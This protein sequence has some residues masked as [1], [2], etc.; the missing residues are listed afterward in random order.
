MWWETRW[1]VVDIYIKNVII[2]TEAQT[3]PVYMAVYT[4]GGEYYYM[5]DRTLEV[6]QHR[7]KLCRGVVVFHIEGTDIPSVHRELLAEAR[8]RGISLSNQL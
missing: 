3:V 1:I 7:L 8:K 6:V 2:C 4:A 5:H